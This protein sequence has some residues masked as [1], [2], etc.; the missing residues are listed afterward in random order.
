V[1]GLRS[2]C[3]RC[4]EDF[5]QRGLSVRFLANEN[6]PGA[7]IGALTDAGHDIVSV[8]TSAPGM[9]DPEVLAWA[10]RE[11]RVLLTFDKDFGE[12]AGKASLPAGCG[13]IL[14]RLPMPK[15]G[16]VGQRLAGL[17]AGRNDWSGHFSVI[18]PG[19]VRLRKLR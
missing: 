17:I 12:L 18:Q 13:V 19:R 4:G 9:T 1:P 6:F 8:R 16:D 3:S 2:G 10:A 7:A 11:Q 14:F 15:P 5:P